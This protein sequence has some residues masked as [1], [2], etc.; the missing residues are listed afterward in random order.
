M[1][2]ALRRESECRRNLVHFWGQHTLPRRWRDASRI[3]LPG[4]DSNMD[5]AVPKSEGAAQ[6][7]LRESN[8][9]AQ[10]NDYDCWSAGADRYHQCSTGAAVP[11]DEPGMVGT[12]T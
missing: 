11:G 9:A 12:A 6:Q 5:F 4:E 1:A 10:A 8:R 2:A 7:P 3:R